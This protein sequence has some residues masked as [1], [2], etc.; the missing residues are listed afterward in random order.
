MTFEIVLQTEPL[1]LPATVPSREGAIVRFEG[2]VRPEENGERIAALEYE[3]YQPMAEQQIGKILSELAQIH[4]CLHA[5]I[6]HRLGRI[7]VGD[8]AIIMEV[9]ATHRA[10]AFALASTFMD[11][12]KQDVPIW[13]IGTHPP[14]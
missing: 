12:L 4:P 9:I 6:Y 1:H 10:E 5:R 11:R 13:K 7:P 8:A 14:S 2:R 3:A